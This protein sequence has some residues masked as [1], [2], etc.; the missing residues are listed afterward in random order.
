MEEEREGGS[1]R[2]SHGL[3]I[4]AVMVKRGKDETLDAQSS[5]SSLLGKDDFSK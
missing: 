5:C 1:I 4:K 3:P 2:F